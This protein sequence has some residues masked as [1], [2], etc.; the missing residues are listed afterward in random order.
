[1]AHENGGCVGRFG[2]VPQHAEP[3]AGLNDDDRAALD[4]D[5][6][7]APISQEHET[8]VPQPA[9]K[10]LDLSELLRAIGELA[11]ALRQLG[12]DAVHRVDHGM[13]V[14]GGPHHVAKTAIGFV[15]EIVQR[16]RIR[17]ACHLAMHERLPGLSFLGWPHLLDPAILSPFD[18]D[19][20]VDQ[21]FDG[22]PLRVQELAEGV[23]DERTLGDVRP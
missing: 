23:D 7:V 5:Q 9:Q 16:H 11:H 6:V 17:H 3:R 4:L 1:M 2:L 14:V 19:H 8:P 15:T 13:E 10:R 12:D 22:K 20:R 21:M 18:V